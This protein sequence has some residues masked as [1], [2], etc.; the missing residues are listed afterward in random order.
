MQLEIIVSSILL[1][2]QSNNSA[3]YSTKNFESNLC[4]LSHPLLSQCMQFNVRVDWFHVFLHPFHTN[5]QA[6][7]PHLGACGDM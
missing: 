1:H 5:M 6:F 3:L 7:F 2:R 4:I